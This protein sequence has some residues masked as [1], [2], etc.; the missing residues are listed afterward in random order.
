VTLP[1]GHVPADV[2]AG[3]VAFV[4]ARLDE[5]EA[6]AHGTEWCP[7]TRTFNGWDVHRVDEDDY[8]VR[9]C[10]ATIVRNVGP[11]FAAHIARHDPENT[12]RRIA[13]DRAILD[14]YE[15]VA[16]L[17]TETGAYDYA[18]GHAVGLGHAVRQMAARDDQHPDYQ[19]HWT[20]GFAR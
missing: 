16:D 12:L 19:P 11:E 7:S 18:T 13:R 14:A 2:N 6:V 9:W 1:L 8:E 17:D 20:Q 10:D 4:R 15:E 3:L 5:A